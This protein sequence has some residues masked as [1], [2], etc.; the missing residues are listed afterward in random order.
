MLA[1]QGK[2]LGRCALIQDVV[3]ELNHIYPSCLDAAIGLRRPRI[4]HRNADPLDLAL[5]AELLH[6]FVPFRLIVPTG[7]PGMEIIHIQTIY[8]EIAQAALAAVNEI[9]R[10]KLLTYLRDAW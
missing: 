2:H 9:L 4:T 1:R 5:L 6:G 8:L 10:R 3:D 7:A